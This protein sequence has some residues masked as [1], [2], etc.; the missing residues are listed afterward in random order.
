[1][2]LIS[3]SKRIASRLYQYLR[4]AV[5]YARH[6]VSGTSYAEYYADRMNRIFT[7]NPDWVLNL[8]RRFQLEYLKAR[9]LV[10]QSTLLDHVCAALAAGIHFIGYLDPLKYVGLDISREVLRE[11]ERRLDRIGLTSRQPNLHLLDGGE[12]LPRH[13]FALRQ[14]LSG[15]MPPPIATP[16]A[17]IQV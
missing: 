12:S 4:E 5:W 7:R 3:L 2:A 11:G 16:D 17:C 8:N 14:R 13:A 10:P 15:P 6:L 9:G 1:M